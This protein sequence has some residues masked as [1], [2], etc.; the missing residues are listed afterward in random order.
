VASSSLSDRVRAKI[1]HHNK[2]KVHSA[3][4]A[5][6]YLARHDFSEGARWADTAKAHRAIVEALEELLS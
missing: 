6:R 2:A 5:Q 3:Q 4:L 1:V